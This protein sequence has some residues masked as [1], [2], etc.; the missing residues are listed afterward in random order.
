MDGSLAGEHNCYELRVTIQALK[1]RHQKMKEARE[2]GVKGVFQG[3][4]RLE[5]H[6]EDE[7]MLRNEETS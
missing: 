7:K 1:T 2:G 4:E 5:G 6:C 3:K